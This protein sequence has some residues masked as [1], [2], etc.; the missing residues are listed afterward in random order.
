MWGIF[1]YLSWLLTRTFTTEVH[2]Y[3]NTN[4]PVNWFGPMR[5]TI[6]RSHQDRHVYTALE[7]NVEGSKKRPCRHRLLVLAERTWPHLWNNPS[8]CQQTSLRVLIR[9]CVRGDCMFVCQLERFRDWV[10]VSLRSRLIF[11]HQWL[12]NDRE[13]VAV[14]I[15]YRQ[16]HSILSSTNLHGSVRPVVLTLR[17]HTVV[18]SNGFV[19]LLIEKSNSLWSAGNVKGVKLTAFFDIDRPTKNGICKG[20]YS[21]IPSSQQWQPTANHREWN[22]VNRAVAVQL[23]A[24]SNVAV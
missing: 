12:L 23:F 3:I 20:V 5:D 1:L 18:F 14:V 7:T 2:I 15:R 11:S 10:V 22:P 13:S 4:K 19:M 24:R 17:K 16:N 21:R 9:E 6:F 8:A